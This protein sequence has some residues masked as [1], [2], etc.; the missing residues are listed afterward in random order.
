M[1]ASGQDSADDT[2]IAGVVGIGIDAV[3]IVRF[4]EV[5]ARRDGMVE[6]M[7]TPGEREYADRA[8]DPTQRYAARF[9]AKEAL[10]KSLGVG[11]G[12]FGFH[13]AEVQRDDDGRP[14][15]LLRGPAEALRIDRGVSEF[16]LSLTHT[17]II[18]QAI[19]IASA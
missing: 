4:R 14:S 11:L 2:G 7:F 13:D 17:D 15:L 12:A 10:M 1:T 3:D 9:A 5:L 19:V 8:N 18:A 16:H 6:R